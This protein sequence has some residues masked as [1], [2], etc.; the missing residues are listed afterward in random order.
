M[1]RT[2]KKTRSGKD[3]DR[4]FAEGTVIDDALAQGVQEA[5]RRHK[6]AGLPIAVWRNGKTVWI[7][8]EKIELVENGGGHRAKSTG[9]S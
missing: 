7:P 3:I 4:I 6:Q 5:L 9:T 8:P 1:K 2:P